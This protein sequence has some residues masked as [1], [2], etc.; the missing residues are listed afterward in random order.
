MRAGTT[1]AIGRVSSYSHA[2]L[3][4]RFYFIDLRPYAR[5]YSMHGGPQFQGAEGKV[6]A[7]AVLESIRTAVRRGLTVEEAVAKFKPSKKSTQVTAIFKQ[8][9]DWIDSQVMS[10]D[11]SENSSSELRRVMEA[12][13]TYWQGTC[14]LD[15][16][17]SMLSQWNI[18]MAMRGLSAKTRSLYLGYL[19][20]ALNHSLE[21]GDINALPK[22]PVIEVPKR[23]RPIPTMDVV[24]QVIERISFEKRGPFL[25]MSRMGIRPAE[26][27]ALDV[28]DVDR[29]GETWRLAINKSVKGPKSS[30]PI[31][32]TKE[33]E[34]RVLPMP[35]ELAEYLEQTVDWSGRL[36]REPLFSTPRSH[37]RFSHGALYKIWK[38]AAQGITEAGLY[39]GT[40][41]AF[42]S[43]AGNAN[44][45]RDRIAAFMGHADV[46][47]TEIYAKVNTEGL[48]IWSQRG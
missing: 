40:K 21:L 28:A 38:T 6:I 8:Y 39:V 26:C 48:D 1:N 4:G 24:D 12:E 13:V 34:E 22:F 7:T 9:V 19:K 29:S 16:S 18:S 2:R 5:I 25:L 3:R 15:L 46:K 42:G 30:S 44:I 20:T 23:V 36:T 47:S 45:S 27:R 14:A 33:A 17:E 11:R 35:T 43:H 41:H 37:V 31:G 10:G 32:K